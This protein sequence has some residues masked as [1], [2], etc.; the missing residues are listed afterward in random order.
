MISYHCIAKVL[1]KP[2]EMT[3]FIVLRQPFFRVK[4]QVKKA[5]LK[6]QVQPG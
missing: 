4:F 1:R 3:I 2:V 6:F 5:V